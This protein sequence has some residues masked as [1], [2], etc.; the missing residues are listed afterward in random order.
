MIL[1]FSD[2]AWEDYLQWQQLDKRKIN[3]INLLIRDATRAPFE[4]IGRPERLRFDQ[5]GWWSRRIDLEH[6]MVYRI[7][8]GA[9]QIAA[10][11][12]HY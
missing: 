7:Q 4:G 8:G 2:Q 9:L 6:R 1:Q 10:L 3:R 12:H 5:S 11:R